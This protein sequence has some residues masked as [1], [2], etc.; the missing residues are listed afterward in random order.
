MM[1]WKQPNVF[2]STHPFYPWL[3]HLNLTFLTMI[4]AIAVVAPNV[5]GTLIRGA[6]QLSS[7]EMRWV[8][9]G[10]IMMLGLILPLGVW[11]AERFGYKKIIF[12][13]TIIFILGSL[14]SA[15][16]WEFYSCLLGRNLLG[17]G[18]GMILPLANTILVQVMPRKN[19]APALALYIGFG[20]GVA[21]GLGYVIGGFFSQYVDW[22][23]IFLFITA[24]SLPS[25]VL[26]AILH[27]ETESKKESRF[28]FIGFFFFILFIGS[29]LLVINSGK[30]E[31]NTDGWTS[32]FIVTTSAIGLIGLI[33][34]I[35][36]ELKHPQ[37]LILLP[38]LKTH[39]FTLG[40]ISVAFGAIVT[41]VTMTIGPIL[42]IQYL[43][44]DFWTG[45]LIIAPIGLTIGVLAVVGAWLTKI[46][47]IRWITLFG[48]LLLGIG[49]YINV[50]YTLYSS[51]KSFLWM[52]NIRA[53][54]I[55]FALG[56]ATALAMSEI[57]KALAGPASILVIL[58]RQVTGTIGTAATETVIT[59]RTQFHNQIFG[60][61]MDI[62]SPRIQQV[63]NHLSDR[64]LQ[65]GGAASPEEAQEMALGV[66]RENVIIQSQITSLNDAFYIIALLIF[67]VTVL[68]FLEMI[69]N[70]MKNSPSEPKKAP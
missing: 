59:Q 46:I 57:P 34:L 69:S 31:W 6:L 1:N 19:L 14:L 3:I 38:L 45:G 55:A 37:P 12:M 18:A 24:A 21:A 2:P 5:A 29:L 30:A 44:Y 70:K 40:S 58:F 56:P 7:D 54:G 47:D 42:T 62:Q 48:L 53:A 41:Y 13:G 66:I 25:L 61:R 22:Q 33:L 52:Y 15:F 67:G 51:H 8:G 17:I 49:C 68:L 39:S 36:W 23:M 32:P 10:Y 50:D 9:I 60:A 43:K 63:V 4:T 11:L 27:Q 65:N 28:D 20:F 64:F 35:P 26:I 16:C